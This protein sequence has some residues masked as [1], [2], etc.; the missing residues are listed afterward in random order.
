MDPQSQREVAPGLR[1]ISV[2]LVFEEYLHEG[3][4]EALSQDRNRA[5]QVHSVLIQTLPYSCFDTNVPSNNVSDFPLRN[6]SHSPPDALLMKEE[7]A[8]GCQNV[9][10]PTDAAFK[11]EISMRHIT[12]IKYIEF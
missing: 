10:S 3:L 12:C 11:F 4:L 6:P 5:F 1:L 2:P 7:W 9:K 8:F